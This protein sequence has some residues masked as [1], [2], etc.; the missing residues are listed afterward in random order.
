MPFARKMVVDGRL[1]SADPTVSLWGAMRCAAKPA[2]LAP[3][4]RLGATLVRTGLVALL[5]LGCGGVVEAE[6]TERLWVSAVPTTAKTSIS[7]FATTRHGDDTYIGAFF[8]GTALRGGHNAFRWRPTGQARA[9]LEFLQDGAKVDVR[10]ER[11]KPTT[12]FDHCLLVRGDPTGAVKY[13]S[14]NRWV[15]KRPG[16]RASPAFVFEALAEVAQDDADVSAWLTGQES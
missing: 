2:R 7:A 11:C 14:R 4:S 1:R 16:R 3:A 8:T 15:V 10:L 12:G 9:Q 6:A 5:P 13:Q